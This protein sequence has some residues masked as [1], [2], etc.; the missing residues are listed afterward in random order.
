MRRSLYALLKAPLLGRRFGYIFF[1]ARGGGRG[2][3]RR[4][5]E[6]LG[7]FFCLKIQEGGSRGGE[8]PR[9]GRESAAN[10]GIGGGG[11]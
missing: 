1:S 4:R 3:P 6:G 11:G 2:S 8:G 10:W 7:R 9:A 5:E